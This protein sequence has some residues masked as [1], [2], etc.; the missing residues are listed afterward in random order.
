MLTLTV[1]P[2]IELWDG[3][4]EEFVTHTSHYGQLRLEHSLV[5]ISKWESI[6]TTP[7]FD[8]KEKT[9]EQIMEYIK[10]MT[11]DTVDDEIYSLITSDDILTINKY[12]SNPMT[13]TTFKNNEGSKNSEMITSELIYYWMISS[14]IPLECENWHI[15]RLLTLIRVCSL[16]NAPSKKM[17]KNETISNY[18]SINAARKKQLRTKG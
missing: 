18:A 12:I 17:S 16:K 11:I 5:A 13:A 3:E 1:N 8:N 6:Y 15:N 10:C 4:K 2:T 9:P 7:F 14:N